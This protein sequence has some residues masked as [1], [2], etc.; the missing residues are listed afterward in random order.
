[1]IAQLGSEVSVLGTTICCKN[2]ED[3][4]VRYQNFRQSNKALY[5]DVDVILLSC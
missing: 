1:M 3:F 5:S 4:E 2:D